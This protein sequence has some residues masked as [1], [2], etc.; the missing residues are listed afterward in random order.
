MVYRSISYDDPSAIGYLDGIGRRRIINVAVAQTQNTQSLDRYDKTTSEFQ[1]YLDP[2]TAGA[3]HH[4][5][6]ARGRGIRKRKPASRQRLARV[7]R[8]A[9]ER[10]AKLQRRIAALRAPPS[11]NTNVQKIQPLIAT[12]VALPVEEENGDESKH[13]FNQLVNLLATTQKEAPVQKPRKRVRT[14]VV[15]DTVEGTKTATNGTEEVILKKHVQKEDESGDCPKMSTDAADKI[16]EAGDTANETQAT[17]AVAAD[18]TTTTD[19]AKMNAADESIVKETLDIDVSDNASAQEVAH[20]EL[21]SDEVRRA[22]SSLPPL[23]SWREIA[24]VGRVRATIDAAASDHV[25]GTDVSVLGLPPRLETKWRNSW[26]GE[27]TTLTSAISGSLRDFR[28]VIMTRRILL[29]TTLELRRVMVAHA[30]A[31][32]QRTRARVVRHDAARSGGTERPEHRDQGYARPRI[33]FLVPMR[34]T[35]YEIVNAILTLCGD[36]AQ[37]AHKAR[38]EREFGREEDDATFAYEDV[39]ACEAATKPYERGTIAKPSDFRYTFR[40]NVDDDFKLGIALA[41]RQ[42]KLYA[43]FYRS[44]II[45]AS[46]LGLRRDRD[47]KASGHSGA[48]KRKADAKE[49]TEWKSSLAA[50]PDKREAVDDDDG[51]LSSIE[52]CIVDDAHIL[53]MQ[54][55]ESFLMTMERVNV[56]P[57]SVRDT[58]FS[59]L[60]EWSLDGLMRLCRQTIVIAAYRSAALMA[61]VRKLSNHSGRLLVAES[62]SSRGTLASSLVSLR[63]T[64]VKV[65]GATTPTEVPPVRLSHFKATTLPHIR[66]MTDAQTLIVIPTYFDFVRLRNLLFEVK[67][68]EPDF[69]FVSLYEY[70]R[71]K[72]VARNR[73]RFLRKQVNIALITERFHFYW[74]HWI[75][76]VSTVVWYALP[77]NAHFYPEF[78]NMTKETVETGRTA[79]SIALF[80]RFDAFALERIVGLK[81]SKRMLAPN[82]K[83]TFLFIT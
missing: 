7:E 47:A 13:A 41:R 48:R 33:L 39:K 49:D 63:H 68:E 76:G 37:V 18:A 56:M 51:F 54:N 21:S 22:L 61:F 75:R 79:Q 27:L 59:R 53:Q 42:V 55:W 82:A 32:I 10:D 62:A 72:D 20:F 74:R 71:A 66:S 43:D 40:D 80:D 8:S 38:F 36:D 34:N 69:D 35:A 30:I 81:R 60:R 65:D 24:G 70:G 19:D 73:T 9:E 17:D 2:P 26:G 83:S 11:T 14:Q 58:D 12:K 15:I 50:E 3:H 46:P 25:S 78:I 4:C 31:H 29:T 45:I 77:C 67:E 1:S 52:V 5:R 57:K 64:F 16:D 44:D 23:S 28:D 6:M